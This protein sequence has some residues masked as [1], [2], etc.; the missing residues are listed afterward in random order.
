M[1]KNVVKFYLWAENIWF[2]YIPEKL[3]YLLVGSFNTSTS[4]LLYYI[5]LYIT[6]GRE[7]LALLL[8]NLININI[9]IATMRYYVFRSKG[10][11]W[12]E[13]Q[14]AFGSYVVLY[15]FNIGLLHFFVKIIKLRENIRP[16]N[17][18]YNVPNLNKAVAQI[19]CICIVTII[20]FF[21]HKY[22]SFRKKK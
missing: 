10:S 4:F 14:K 2:S 13:Y 19:C 9:S 15:F 8:M 6:N 20:T 3:R 17:I 1:I 22:F 11:F 21:V 16:E 5:F 7:Q 12:L 18:L